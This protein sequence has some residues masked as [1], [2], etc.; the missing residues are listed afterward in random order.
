MLYLGVDI[1]GMSIKCAFVNREGEMLHKFIIPLIKGEEQEITLAKIGVAINKNIESSHN[2][3]TD[4]AGIGVGC[5]GSINNITGVCAFAG[6]LGWN[7][8]PVGEKIHQV[9]GLPVKVT[10]DANAAMLGEALFGIGKKYKNLVLLTLGT[11]IGGGLYLNGKLYEGNEGKGAELGHMVIAKGGEYCTCGQNGC[12]EAYA[13]ASALIK[14]TKEAMKE[15][16]GSMMWAFVGGDIEKVDGKTAFECAKKG[17]MTALKVVGQYEDY[18]VIGISNLCN[19][20]RPEAVILGGGLSKQGEYLTNAI[21]MKLKANH[22]GFKGT[23]AVEV[24]VSKLGNDAGI[25]GAAAL[26]ID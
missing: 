14:E 26:F 23:P 7:N 19:I 22:Y 11:G 20:F 4:F 5:P 13:S 24:L 12:F 18:L 15:D 9:T 8:A 10:N 6:N 16:S 1:G 2:K 3:K 17:D 25:L 21:T